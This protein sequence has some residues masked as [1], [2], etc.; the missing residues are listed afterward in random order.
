MLSKE[1]E[2]TIRKNLAR[3]QSGGKLYPS[4]YAVLERLKLVYRRDVWEGYEYS[5]TDK[6]IA[7][8]SDND[9]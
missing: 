1:Q 2:E 7:F 9:N 6:G 8:L 4:Q 3:V 5:L